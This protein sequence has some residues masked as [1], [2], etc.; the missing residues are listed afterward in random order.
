M[1]FVQ[2]FLFCFSDCKSHSRSV[3]NRCEEFLVVSP[4]IGYGVYFSL[5]GWT[6]WYVRRLKVVAQRFEANA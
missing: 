3:R 4:M 2:P 1:I 5:I 6:F